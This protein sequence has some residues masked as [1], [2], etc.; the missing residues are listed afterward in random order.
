MFLI[1]WASIL[2]GV[3]SLGQSKFSYSSQCLTS[4]SDKID[5]LGI[6]LTAYPLH[7]LVPRTQGGRT[8]REV[9]KSLTILSALLSLVLKNNRCDPL[10]YVAPPREPKNLPPQ[11]SYSS[12]CS[13]TPEAHLQPE[14]DRLTS[15]PEADRLRVK[16]YSLRSIAL[17]C[18]AMRALPTLKNSVRRFVHA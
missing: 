9:S 4:L 16:K 12:Q 3:A 7:S 6:T 5:Q 10:R 15:P 8:L 17:L 2:D 1:A 11:F 18:R 13:R 14:A